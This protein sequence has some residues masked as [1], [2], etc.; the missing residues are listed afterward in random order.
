MLY[1]LCKDVLQAVY[2]CFQYHLHRYNPPFISPSFT[3]ARP[4]LILQLRRRDISDTLQGYGKV[5]RNPIA[6]KKMG[7]AKA[8]HPKKTKNQMA[9]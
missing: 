9:K 7:R 1:H 8:L 5:M 3:I 2:P 4:A 6:C